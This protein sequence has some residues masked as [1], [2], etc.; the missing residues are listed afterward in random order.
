M[1]SKNVRK[2]YVKDISL[3]GQEGTQGF[4]VSFYISLDLSAYEQD[5]VVSNTP[6]LFSF[7]SYRR[8]LIPN[9]WV[10][11]GGLYWFTRAPLLGYWGPSVGWLKRQLGDW[12]ASVSSLGRLCWATGAPVSASVGSLGRFCWVTRTPHLGDSGASVSLLGRLC[13][14]TAAPLLVL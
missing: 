13:W 2:N 3:T 5:I 8:S 12:G 4:D 14:A 9:I 6:G 11:G 1:N 7:P 10:T